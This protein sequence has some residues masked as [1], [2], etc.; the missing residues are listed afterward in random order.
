MSADDYVQYLTKRFMTYLDTPKEERIKRRSAKGK[1]PWH[2]HWF[3]DAALSMQIFWR[4]QK[5]RYGS[6]FKHK[7]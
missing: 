6:R 5:E 4:R 2:I 1:E 7:M 3:G